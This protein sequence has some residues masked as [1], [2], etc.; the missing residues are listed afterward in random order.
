MTIWTGR[1]YDGTYGLQIEEPVL[2]ALDQMST[3][4][5]KWLKHVRLA[6]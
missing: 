1:T 4:S 3:A 5:R 6:C 2:R